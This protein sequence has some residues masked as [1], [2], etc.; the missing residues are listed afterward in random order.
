MKVF[1][2]LSL[3]LGSTSG[4]D[5]GAKSAVAAKT[6]KAAALDSGVQ[7][8]CSDAMPLSVDVALL[9]LAVT[10]DKAANIAKARQQIAEAVATGAQLVVLPEIWNSPY[11]TAAF[12]EYAEGIPGGPSTDMLTAAA[13]EHGIWIVGGSIPEVDSTGKIFNSCPIV[14]PD[15]TIVAVHRKGIV[16]LFHLPLLKLL[17][18][19]LPRCMFAGV[20]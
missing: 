8:S 16:D 14:S 6:V 18:I 13:Q 1:L 3:L 19:E 5:F 2:A 7:A 9:Q 20:L 11:A 10:G 4:F 15:G 17:V 12:P